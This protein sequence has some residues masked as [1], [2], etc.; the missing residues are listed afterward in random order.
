VAIPRDHPLRRVVLRSLLARTFI[1]RSWAFLVFG[2]QHPVDGKALRWIS[3]TVFLATLSTEWISP[4]RRWPSASLR[5]AGAASLRRFS[6]RRK[7]GMS[8]RDAEESFQSKKDCE[9]ELNAGKKVCS[10]QTQPHQ[11]C[12]ECKIISFT[13]RKW[14]EGAICRHGNGRMIRAERS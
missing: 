4:R 8:T 6:D 12:A 7:N 11:A 2:H 10:K 9:C 13:H 1:Q 5:K 3:L 14:K